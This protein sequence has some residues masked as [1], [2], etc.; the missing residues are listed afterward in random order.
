MNGGGPRANQA[1][2]SLGASAKD[3]PGRLRLIGALGWWG[4]EL[5]RLIASPG[6]S[7][8]RIASLRNHHGC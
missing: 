3:D 2:G 5:G 1:A 4:F 8:N 6:I 7:E